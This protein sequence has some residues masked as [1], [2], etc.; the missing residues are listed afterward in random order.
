MASK[1]TSVRRRVAGAGALGLIAF[2]L[3]LGSKFGGFGLGSG[4]L[5][6]GSGTDFKAGQGPGAGGD[7]ADAQ[8]PPSTE[9]TRVGLTS[10]SAPSTGNA[11]VDSE[12]PPRLRVILDGN[13][14]LIAANDDSVAGIPS[15]PAAV[16]ERVKS[17][18]GDDQGILIRIERTKRATSGA[19]RELLSALESAGVPRE[20]IQEA[21]DFLD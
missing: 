16:V 18:P 19:R 10:L 4:G 2:G 21:T 1:K 5:G 14:V 7:A 12:P 20:A 6:L 13:Q 3:W 11:D 17:L 9:N 8:A 15:T